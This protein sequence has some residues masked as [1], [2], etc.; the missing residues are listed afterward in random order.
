MVRYGADGR[1]TRN[2]A[3]IGALVFDTPRNWALVKALLRNPVTP[4]EYVFIAEHLRARLLA[5]ALEIGEDTD[6]VLEAEEVLRQPS[7]SLPH[8]DHMHVRIYCPG[9]D[10]ALGCAELGPLRWF[11]K[12][13]KYA[14]LGM[15]VRFG[16]S[17]PRFLRDTSARMSILA[18]LASSLVTRPLLAW[19]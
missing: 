2:D 12:N 17:L 5:Y 15:P 16:L 13:Y 1:G 6:L 3:S 10:L 11:K 18:R 7:D 14:A 4:V 8:D 9:T 19:R